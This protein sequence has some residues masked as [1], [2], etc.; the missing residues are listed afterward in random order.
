MMGQTHALSGAGVFLA[1]SFPLSATVGT[2]ALLN[3]IGAS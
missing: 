2:V 3:T 1:V